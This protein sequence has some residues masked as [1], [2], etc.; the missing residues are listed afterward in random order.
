VRNPLVN[1]LLPRV[2]PDRVLDRVIAR[3]L[4]LRRR[5]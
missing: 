5:R 1:W 4:G 2:L 3:Q